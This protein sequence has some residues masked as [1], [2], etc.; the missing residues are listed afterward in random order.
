MAIDGKRLLLDRVQAI[1]FD[2]RINFKFED[3]DQVVCLEYLFK[4]K[5]RPRAQSQVN[6]ISESNLGQ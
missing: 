1:L 4:I 5:N 6:G 3:R 2:K